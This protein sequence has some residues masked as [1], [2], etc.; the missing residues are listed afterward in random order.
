M[1]ALAIEREIHEQLSLMPPE[2]QRQVLDFARTLAAKQ[3]P[4]TSGRSLMRFAGAIPT[5]DLAVM[6][7]AIEE[8]CEQ[9]NPDD[10]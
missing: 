2:K 8:G 5:E 9:V 7:S 3:H 4:S 6:A 10:W 1:N